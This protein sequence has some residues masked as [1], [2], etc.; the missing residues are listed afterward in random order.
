MAALGRPGKG[1]RLQ[2]RCEEA[3]ASLLADAAGRCVPSPGESA[4]TP[5]KLITVYDRRPGRN[6]EVS[7]LSFHGKLRAYKQAV[8][9]T[10]VSR[11]QP[12]GHI[13]PHPLL[14]I[15]FYWDPALLFTHVLGGCVRA[16]MPSRVVAGDLTAGK[17]ANISRLAFRTCVPPWTGR[18]RA[19]SPAPGR[20]VGRRGS[21]RWEVSRCPPG[22]P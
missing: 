3:A 16:A 11:L 15:K 7:P 12:R 5:R 18:A 6:A 8:A 20:G 9:P 10:R 19:S 17:A 4:E 22:G 21:A 14:S 1:S 2:V 13:G